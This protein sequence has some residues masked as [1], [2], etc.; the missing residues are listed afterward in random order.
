MSMLKALG[1]IGAVAGGYASGTRQREEM[2]MRRETQ[3]RQKQEWAKQDK[4]EADLAAASAPTQVA[5]ATTMSGLGSKPIAFDNPGDAAEAQAGLKAA[6]TETTTAPGFT[7]GG[8]SFGTRAEADK[9]ATDFNSDDATARRVANAYGANG[10]AAQAMSVRASVKQGQM[11]DI[12]LRA[13][14]EAEK[15]HAGLRE[16]AT[17]LARDG[18]GGVPALYDRY[19]DGH[20]VRVEEDGKGGATLYRLDGEGKELGKKSYATPMAFLQDSMLRFDPKLWLAGQQQQENRAQD[21]KNKDR[22]LTVKEREADSRAELRTAQAE[23]GMLRAQAAMERAQR[24][25]AVRGAGDQGLTMEHL[26]AVNREL[27]KSATDFFNPKES[28]TPQ[29]REAALIKAQTLATTGTNIYRSAY[30]M[31]VPITQTEALAAATAAG[32]TKNIVG[33]AGSDGKLYQGVMVQGKFVPIGG[34]ANAASPGAAGAAPATASMAAAAKP[35]KD[36]RT[37]G[38][39]QFG[40]VAKKAGYTPSQG[41]DGQWYFSRVVDGQGENLT[42]EQLAKRLNVLY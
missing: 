29:E 11:A 37:A 7:A 27:F 42:G 14:Q 6:G 26:G 28:G 36:T 21:Q 17:G 38:D 39:I 19:D 31:G 33:R 1:M 34:T 2:D 9:A 8:K 16:F 41:R 32:D 24:A 4:L 35:V 18:W 5:D 40:E 12:Q 10:Q 13:A 25:A 23:N 30:G 3:N 22:E 15:Q 20:K